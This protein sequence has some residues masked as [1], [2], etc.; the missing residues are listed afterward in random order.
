MKSEEPRVLNI[1]KSDK[2]DYKRLMEKDS[3]FAGKD[4][5]DLFLM[6][7]IMGF[8]E[9]S[10]IPLDKKESYVRIEYLTDRE[11][12]IIKSIA[13]ADEEDLNIL[14]NKRRV[15]S[16]AEEYAAGGIK[17]L[18]EKVFGYG[19]FMKKLE[20]ELVEEFEKI[21]TRKEGEL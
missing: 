16:I 17:L 7:M 13:V 10:R 19:S 1:R 4:D 15:Y 12:S 5:K 9:G 18:K 6:A 11:K 21:K 3:P 2:E 20:A 8:C 14:A